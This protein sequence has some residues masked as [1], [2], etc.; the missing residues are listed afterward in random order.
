ME[1]GTEVPV[2]EELAAA[3]DGTAEQFAGLPA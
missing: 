3:L 1:N 2:E